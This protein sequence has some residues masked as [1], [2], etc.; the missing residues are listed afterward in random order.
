MLHFSIITLPAHYS[1]VYPLLGIYEIHSSDSTVINT[2]RIFDNPWSQTRIIYKFYAGDF[3]G[4]LK[5]FNS[6]WN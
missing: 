3:E 5:I 6:S 4:N 1:F 2:S